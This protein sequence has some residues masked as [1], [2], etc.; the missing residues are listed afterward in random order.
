M[1]YLIALLAVFGLIGIA[2]SAEAASQ[3]SVWA[4]NNGAV[5]V[6]HAGTGQ[7]KSVSNCRKATNLGVYYIT[8]RGSLA[9]IHQQS[10]GRCPTGYLLRSIGIAHY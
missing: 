1:K 5:A 4:Y 9:S 7:Y 6:C 10:Y 3:C 8:V 2:D